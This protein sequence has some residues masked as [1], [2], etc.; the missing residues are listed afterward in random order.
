MGSKQKSETPLYKEL[1]LESHTQ[2]LMMKTQAG[3]RVANHEIDRTKNNNE[4]EFDVV[5][6]YIHFC[7]HVEP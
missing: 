6:N 1:P 3:N 2:L 7:S 4:F 5:A